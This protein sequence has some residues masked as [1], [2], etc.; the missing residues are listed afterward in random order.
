[1]M[2]KN[3]RIMTVLLI[4]LIILPTVS[5]LS[6]ENE[7]LFTEKS[8]VLFE[9]ESIETILQHEGIY[10]EGE[11]TYSS[12]KPAIATVSEDGVITAVNKGKTDITVTLTQNNKR[13]GRK[14]AHIRVNVLRA[15]TGVGLDTE[16]LAVYEP[17]DPAI[18]ELMKEQ[19]KNR[20]LVLAAGKTVKL[21]TSCIPED[22]SVKKVAY[23]SSDIN[24]VAIQGNTLKALRK[25]ECDLT[26][27]SVQNPEVTEKYHVLVVLPVR[28]ITIYSDSKRVG[29]STLQLSA[30][31]SPE[32]ASV[33]F[34]KW[35]SKNTDIATV[36]ENGVV[37]GW[38]KGTVTI[39][40]SAADGSN[41]TAKIVLTVTVNRTKESIA[42]NET[43]QSV[44]SSCPSDEKTGKTTK[45]FYGSV[46]SYKKDFPDQDRGI[47]TW[48]MTIQNGVVVFCDNINSTILTMKSKGNTTELIPVARWEIELLEAIPEINKQAQR[49][50]INLI[51][52]KHVNGG[53]YEKYADK[54]G[55]I[56][57]L[58]EGKYYGVLE[59]ARTNLAW[60]ELIHILGQSRD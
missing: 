60:L 43:V 53:D 21:S 24:I 31:C 3:G 33:R 36:D 27:A 38:K 30:V 8:I 41:V 51:A 57:L 45:D 9:G 16:K 48:K 5:S 44:I 20:V 4:I 52:E 40:A 35:R 29:D 22:A 6:A 46:S 13:A 19:P 34:V 14:T 26:I 25:G 59:Q 12:A 49:Q 55:V 37:T 7:F 2:K 32:N 58:D 47:H 50:G 39:V 54:D 11:I 23:T 18:L 15:V 42:E 1:M 17:D 56:D 28:K 10:T